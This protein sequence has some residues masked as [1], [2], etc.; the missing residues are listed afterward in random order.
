MNSTEKRIIH[1][2]KIYST[3]TDNLY[4]PVSPNMVEILC[5][6]LLSFLFLAYSCRA[7]SL[8][9]GSE[10]SYIQSQ[11]CAEGVSIITPGSDAFSSLGVTMQQ[12]YPTI[13]FLSKVI[14]QTASEK[15]VGYIY[16]TNVYRC[17]RAFQTNLLRRLIERMQHM[18]YCSS[19]IA[20]CAGDV[21]QH[22]HTQR[23]LTTRLSRLFVEQRCVEENY[24]AA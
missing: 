3:V 12:N 22:P 7:T 17:R 8:M 1:H 16:I 20:E 9:H 10:S 23:H 14:V 19:V 21:S 5:V 24:K 15:Y 6:L 13:F 18:L 2:F 4:W 11:S